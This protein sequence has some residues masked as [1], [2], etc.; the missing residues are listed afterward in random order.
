VCRQGVREVRAVENTVIL[1][2]CR[3]YSQIVPT[4]KPSR[5]KYCDDFIEFAR[6]TDLVFFDPDNGMEVESV[7]L[8]TENSVKYLYWDEV[9]SAFERGYSLLIYQHFRRENRE[10]FI[11][12]LAVE[13]GRETGAKTVYSFRTPNVV[14]FLIPQEAHEGGLFQDSQEVEQLWRPQISLGRH[15]IG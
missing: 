10:T 9:R 3:F 15:E 1:P 2:G 13:F 12:N 8:G 4:E 7:P 14:F 5:T 6:G 11:K